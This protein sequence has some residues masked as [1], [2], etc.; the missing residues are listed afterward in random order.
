MTEPDTQSPA[1]PLTRAEIESLLE[2]GL[3]DPVK[4][5]RLAAQAAQRTLSGADAD[6]NSRRRANAAE[7][8]HMLSNIERIIFLKGV[9][10]FQGMTIEHLKVIASICEEVFFPQGSRI[11]DAGDPG[12]VMYVVV[13]GRVAIERAATGRAATGRAAG[14]RAPDAQGSDDIER[15][16]REQPTGSTVRLATIEPRAYFGEMSLFDRSP[17]SAM[18]RAIQDTIAL[19]MRR[20]PLVALAR[21]QPDLSLELIHVLSQ[22]LRAANDRIAEL[23][24]A[25]PREIH[26][27][28]DKIL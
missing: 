12:G 21:Q 5:V 9:P 22:R 1:P 26:D 8:V 16:D 7:E 2:K 6:F 18:A 4:D 15:P 10:F 24:R 25:K 13:S 19:S 27:L 23:T 28:Y 17:R 20:E 3:H 11:F 14:G